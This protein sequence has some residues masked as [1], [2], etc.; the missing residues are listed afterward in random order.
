MK[1]EGRPVFGDTIAIFGRSTLDQPNGK[2]QK[3]ETS[4]THRGKNMNSNR[5]CGLREAS[6][7]AVQQ[8][9]GSGHVDRGAGH[10][11]ADPGKRRVGH[12]IVVPHHEQ[13]A[14]MRDAHHRHQ[15]G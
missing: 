11:A 7:G 5:K 1:R 12:G 9:R 13:P 14:S 15:C 10:G 3:N 2:S 8:H 4:E 6:P